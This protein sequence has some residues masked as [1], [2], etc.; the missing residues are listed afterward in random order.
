M[1]ELV[2][3]KFPVFSSST[4]SSIL[5]RSSLFGRTLSLFEPWVTKISCMAN[6][7]SLDVANPFLFISLVNEREGEGTREGPVL[8]CSALSANGC[9]HGVA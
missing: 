3:F 7:A 9:P 1:L 8:I 5:S 2:A 6:V 4:T